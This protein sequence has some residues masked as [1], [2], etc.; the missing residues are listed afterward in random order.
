MGSAGTQGPLWGAGAEDWAEI[1]EAWHLPLWRD[2]LRAARAGPGVR[3]LDAGCGAGGAAAEAARLGCEVIG[4][5][6]SAGMLAIARRRLSRAVLVR[7]DLESL[8]FAGDAFDAVVAINSIVFARNMAGAAREL[9]RVARPGA[10]VV[11]TGRGGPED[12]D[13][14]A[15]SEAVAPFLPD[16]WKTAGPFALAA[17]G[18]V[19]GLLAAARLRPA[20]RGRSLCVYRYPDRETCWRGLASSGPVQAAVGRAGREAVRA[21]VEATIAR[22]VAADT[23]VTLRAVYLWAA[24]ERLQTA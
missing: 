13:L 11:I 12:S 9:S 3:L 15:V 16:E 8:P 24:G 14:T 5:D 1:Q 19:E 20:E 23:T 21:A 17:P 10:R 6:A 22:F 18:A 7:G 2:A 4:L